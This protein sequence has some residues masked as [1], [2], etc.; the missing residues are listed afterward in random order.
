VND[1]LDE[2]P[3]P[4]FQLYVRDWLTGQ[5]TTRMTAEQKGAFIDLLCHAWPARPPCT[6]PNDDVVLARLSGL[7]A[8]WKKVGGL[9]RAQ[10]S[11]G[12]DG[13]L[14]NRKQQEI[15]R[16]LLEFRARKSELGRKGATARWRRTADAMPTHSGTN[17]EA[18]PGGM[19]PTMPQPMPAEWPA[20]ASAS[21]SASA[22][23]SDRARG[24]VGGPIIGRNPHLSH[25]AC[26]ETQSRCV[27]RAV[28]DKLRNLLAPRYGGDRTAAG[29]ALRAWYPSVWATLPADFVMPDA[30]K[31][32]CSDFEKA[33]ASKPPQAERPRNCDHVPRCQTD[34]EHGVRVRAERQPAAGRSQVR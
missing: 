32:W 8:R 7:G 23:E 14:R 4:S 18:M 3:G 19:P 9:V 10:F 33:F 16:E 21:A 12:T 30:F 24:E 5:A 11:V 22:R 34:L 26:D 25:A 20:S 31:F 6:L 17:P 28:D 15:Y 27:P 13:L 2:Q 1:P 29:E